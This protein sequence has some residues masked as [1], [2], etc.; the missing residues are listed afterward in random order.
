MTNTTKPAQKTKAALASEVATQALKN[1][2]EPLAKQI[3]QSAKTP[4]PASAPA[5]APA[6]APAS[7][8]AP[9]PAQA[10]APAPAQA[11]A[12]ASTP[13]PAKAP[14]PA[15]VPAQAKAP[16][17]AGQT[18][19]S[20]PNYGGYSAPTA[21]G[22]LDRP[23]GP[24]KPDT[25]LVQ[26][27]R[28]R[29]AHMS[30]GDTNFRHWLTDYLGKLGH[31]AQ[32][33]PMGCLVITTDPKSR[34]LFSCH[35]DTCHGVVESNGVPQELA[36]DRVM[37]HVFL[38]KE[39]KGAPPACLGADDGV[40]IWIMLKMIEA[41]VAGTYIFHAGE[42]RGGIGSRAVF[43]EKTEWLRHFDRAVAFDRPNDYEVICTQGGTAC[44][45]ITAGSEIVAALLKQGLE[46][47]VSH[48]GSFTDTKVYSP[49]IPEC[50]NLGVGYTN[51]HTPGEDLD[52]IHAEALLKAAIAINWEDIGVYRQLP[53]TVVPIP[54][55]KKKGKN[56]GWQ[57][58]SKQASF[59][60]DD[61]VGG[62][63]YGRPASPGTASRGGGQSTHGFPVTFTASDV[64]SEIDGY[65]L[66]DMDVLVSDEPVVAAQV[67]ALLWVRLRGA[68]AEIH[69]LNKLLG[70][71]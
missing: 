65:S 22:L 64:L 49:V 42:E 68:K 44:A 45:S 40:G 4:A 56:K 24:E 55:S 58:K 28:T 62:Y 29:R 23:D 27:L 16:A 41:K 59:E 14:V 51:Q 69:T 10:P 43:A 57:N 1:A 33:F 6:T 52:I 32:V 70:L 26:I 13:A 38:S 5:T 30:V 46:Y 34:T 21:R 36:Y 54:E 37:G 11:P 8:P 39:Q 63:G 50:F 35:I 20:Y 60:D 7:T 31:K 47:E 18:Y 19:P 17:P 53:S 67:I 61:D 12:P 9:A 15:P 2:K 48:R 25:L 3:A 66:E 71:G